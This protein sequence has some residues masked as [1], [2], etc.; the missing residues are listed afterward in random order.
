MFE[1]GVMDFVRTGVRLCEFDSSVGKVGTA[2]CHCP[3][4]FTNPGLVG[5]LHLFGKEGL[6][7]LVWVAKALNFVKQLAFIG[8][9]VDW[10]GVGYDVFIQVAMWC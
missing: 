10:F 4:E 8:N 1:A 5:Q 9:G 7:H 2:G 6:C 3:Y